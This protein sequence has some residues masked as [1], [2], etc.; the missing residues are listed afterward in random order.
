MAKLLSTGQVAKEVGIHHQTLLRWLRAK[1]IPEPQW[2]NGDRVWTEDD[3]SFVKA[4]KEANYR[5]RL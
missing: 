4:Y 3:V 2:V 1:E 5:K